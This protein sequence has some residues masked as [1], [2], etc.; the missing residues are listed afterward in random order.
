MTSF[1][2]QSV[3]NWECDAWFLKKHYARRLPNMTHCFGLYEGNNLCGV[4]S[5]GP[6]ASPH[7]CRGICGEEFSQ[8]VLEL[9]RLVIDHEDRNAASQLISGSLKMLPK[10]SIIV[11]YADTGVGH[12]GYVYQATN[13]IYTGL[14]ARRFDPKHLTDKNKHSRGKWNPDWE[15]VERSRKHRYIYFCGSKKDKKR[16]RSLLRYA[17]EPYPKGDSQ[18]YD[19]SA[20]VQT[21]MRLI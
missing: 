19:A 9:N 17:V 10:P 5:Y 1:I 13:W 15:L 3:Q 7:L 6:P 14:S 20:E 21:Q 11:S 12:V 16:M 2:I 4:I 18:K 8:I